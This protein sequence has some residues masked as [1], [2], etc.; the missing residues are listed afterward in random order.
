MPHA[1]QVVTRHVDDSSTALFVKDP[2]HP[3]YQ[4]ALTAAVQNACKGQTLDDYYQARYLGNG[5]DIFHFGFRNQNATAPGELVKKAYAEIVV[6]GAHGY[7][8]VQFNAYDSF[9]ILSEVRKKGDNLFYFF[10]QLRQEKRD[11]EKETTEEKAV[12]N[13]PF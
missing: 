9:T 13:C 5:W 6:N 12:F 2:N 8:R 11:A 4:D 10:K 1:T 3:A 7:T